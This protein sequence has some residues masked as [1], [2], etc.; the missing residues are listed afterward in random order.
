[1]RK[2]EPDHDLCQIAD[3][4]S[5]DRS[6]D[7]RRRRNRQFVSN[8]I[9]LYALQGL[10]YAVPLAVLPYLVRA[11]GIERY[12]LLAFAQSFAQ[13]FSLLTDYGFNFSA[14]RSIALQRDDKE[15]VSRIFCSV[16]CIK[17][18]LMCIGALVLSAVV[19]SIPRFHQNAAFFFMAYL[20]VIGN[21]LFPV[22]YFQGV[23]KMKHISAIVGCARPAGAI[24]LFAFVHRPQDALLALAIQSLALVAGGVAGLWVVVHR[25]H[26]SLLRPAASDIRLAFRDGLHLFISTAAVS[27]YTNTNVFL[28]GILSG[29]LEAGYFSAAEKLVRAAAQGMLTPITQAVFPYMSHLV[30]QSREMALRLAARTLRWMSLISL[31][32]SIL[33]FGFA[34]PI[35]GICFGRAAGAGVAVLRW[36]A[37]LPFLIAISNVLGIQTLIPF[38]LDKQLSRVLLAAGLFHLALAVPLIHFFGAPGAGASVLCTESLIAVS[39][40]FV[41]ER[42]HLHIFHLIERPARKQ[43]F[44]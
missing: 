19:I 33:I 22:W 8:L 13:Y 36:I 9:S 1:M 25:F 34:G 42:H 31:V 4:E 28:V 26:V 27:L 2:M 41:L 10:N 29:N 32:A 30:A 40:V 18:L 37:L 38:G 12:G 15:A 24:A 44:S 6:L 3:A 21:V 17:L 20:A 11:L 39:M 43:L 35:V 5:P 16:F 7:D 14:T 23:E